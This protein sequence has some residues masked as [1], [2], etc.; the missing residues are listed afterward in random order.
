MIDL[1]KQFT[2]YARVSVRI[3][4]T[5]GYLHE[6][7]WDGVPAN[8]RVSDIVEHLLRSEVEIIANGQ[9]II[10]RATLM[11]LAVEY[12]KQRLTFDHLFKRMEEDNEA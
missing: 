11:E 3:R 7:Q 5:S 10:V 6:R 4:D 1:E 9:E 2:D 8:K 12:S